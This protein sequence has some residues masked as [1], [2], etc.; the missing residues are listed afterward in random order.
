VSSLRDA[1][2]ALVGDDTRGGSD[3]GAALAQ[4]IDDALIP[5]VAPWNG[6]VPVALVALGSY[7]RRELSP[8]SD[9]DVVLLYGGRRER[10]DPKVRELA[11]RLWYPLWDAGFVTGHGTRSLKQAIA[12]ADADLDALTSYLDIRHVAG[13]ASL[14][15]EL[16]RRGR[17]LA[18]RRRERVLRTLADASRERRAKPGAVAEMLEPDVKE[19]AGG[20]RDLQ[21]LGWAGHTLGEP[22]GLEA[23]RERDFV[24]SDDIERLDAAREH[25]LRIRV[26]LHRATGGRGDRL[27][28]Q[29]QDA[30][31]RQVGAASADD[32]VRALATS[33]RDVAWIVGEAW[34][35]LDDFRAGPRGRVVH[36]DRALAEGVVLREGRVMLTARPPVRALDVLEAAAAAAEIGAPFDR[37]SLVR[38]RD[39]ES[40]SWDV[41]QR[42]AFL[43]LLR[44][45]ARAIPVF[46]ALDHE[47]V[48]TRL[49][50][51][52][53][54]VRSLPQRNAYHRFTVDRHSL[55]A[56]SEAAR[57]LDLAEAEPLEFD[58]VVARACRRP[59]VLLFAALL[60]DMGKGYPGNHSEVGAQTANDIAHRIGLDSEGRELLTWLVRDHLLLADT[61][62]RRDLSDAAV[63]DGV[64]ADC[65]GDGEHLRLLYLLTIADSLATG[66]AAWGPTK[67]ALL[68]DLFVKTA[69]A[70]EQG[71]AEA[72]ADDRRAALAAR[73]GDDAAAAFLAV[74]PPSYPLTFDD[75]TMARHRDLVA[76]RATNIECEV[77]A[78]GRIVATVAAP[79]RRGLLATLAGAL[80]C[81]GLTVLEANLCSTT[82]GMALDVFRASDPF[83]RIERHGAARVTTMLEGALSGD[84]DIAAGVA[85]RARDYWTPARRLGRVDVD[86]D[87]D[88]SD[89]ATVFEVHADDDVGLLYRLAAV[90]AAFDL[91]VTFARVTTLADRVVDVFYVHDAQGGKLADEV[92]IERVRVALVDAIT[93]ADAELRSIRA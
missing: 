93:E 82:D 47:G 60:H 50:P 65:A 51:E 80:T 56:V 12:L 44:A 64:A 11:E 75:E 78:D 55:E 91:D 86:V 69:A 22:G 27:L 52:W 87:L 24:T 28:L 85:A 81:C 77:G 90:F 3:F 49:L 38:L 10:L 32:M 66:P 89:T 54:H 79:D 48:L 26:A 7:A 53:E 83:E 23:L 4:V 36:Q 63:V 33:A 74:M 25:L 15:A 37:G 57:L 14:T 43:R 42:A 17:E 21:A 34:A 92:T 67:A 58:G 35:R 1:R 8:A 39:M 61:A 70:I 68:R 5:V 46:E 16:Q 72:L 59:E 88:A 9:V 20:L 2:D 13:D 18:V 29:E 84:V 41:W 30:V 40:P 76:Q 45:G 62:M 6:P 71:E 31:A 19:G 73:L